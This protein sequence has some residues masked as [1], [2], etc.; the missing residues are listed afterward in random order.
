MRLV[1]A[2]V[3]LAVLAFASLADANPRRRVVVQKV[4]VQQVNVNHGHNAA[5]VVQNRV[6]LVT[7]FVSTVQVQQFHGAAAIQGNSHCGSAAVIQSNSHCGTSAVFVPG[8]SVIRS[9]AFFVGH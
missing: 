5:L 6:R 7:P 9:R 1:F 2:L 3:A 4:V 8:V